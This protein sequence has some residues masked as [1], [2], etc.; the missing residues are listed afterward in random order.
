MTT[1]DERERGNALE[2]LADQAM[3]D[4]VGFESRIA[5]LRDVIATLAA[6]LTDMRRDRDRASKELEQAQAELKIRGERVHEVA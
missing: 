5:S 6:D 4:R 1:D 2:A 3:K